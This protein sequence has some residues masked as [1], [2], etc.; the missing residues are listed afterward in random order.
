MSK[1]I[2]PSGFTFDYQN[3]V[4]ADMVKPE[5]IDMLG[6]DIENAMLAAKKMR[7]DGVVAGHVSKDG[8]PELVLFPQLP[9]IEEAHINS[10]LVMQRLKELSLHA[11]KD[12]SV[13]VSFGIGGSYLGD[14]VLFD[15][16]CGE[17][18][19]A[20]SEEERNGYP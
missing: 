17:F 10:P 18:W 9:Y 12:I 2:L 14:K 4:G 13:A 20:M 8:D 16:H 3:L 11:K 6:Q 5:D 1:L 7:T 19:N 15:V